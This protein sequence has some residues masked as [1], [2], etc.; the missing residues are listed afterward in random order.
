MEKLEAFLHS[1]DFLAGLCG[2]AAFAVVMLVWTA[3]IDN[4]QVG[5]DRLK[6][7]TQRRNEFEREKV[8]KNSRRLKL[9]RASLMKQIVE[10][11]KLSQGKSLADLRLKL[12]RAGYQARDAMFVFL[13]TK[14]ALALGLGAFG[15]FLIFLVHAIKLSGALGILAVLGATILG[16]LL[17][18]IFI[19]NMSQKREEV[20]RKSIPDALD[21]M[22]ICAEAG[23]GL[24]A[25]FDRVGREMAT[26]APELAEELGLTSVELNFLPDRQQALRGLADR[27]PLPSVTA[28]INTLIQTEKYG[29]PLAQALRVL[30]GEMR[31]ERMMRAEEK[32]ARLPAVLTV[33]MIV[34]IL[35][36]LFVV[37]IG[38][39]A[40]KVMSAMK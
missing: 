32:A 34:F 12:R 11:F 4:G 6:A 40:L 7:V 8:K 15:A 33:P 16:W 21:L 35:P 10:W 20:L 27:V 1:P 30:S 39:A 13:F 2:A 3:F 26:S 9:Q 38:P 37:L 17:P 36:P 5:S 19:K 28:L 18:E 23:L 14:L 24:D 25:A 22:V 31:E 29:T